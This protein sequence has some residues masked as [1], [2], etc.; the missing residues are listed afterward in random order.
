MVALPDLRPADL[1]RADLR[2]ADLSRRGLLGAVGAVA[3]SAACGAPERTDGRVR[4]GTEHPDQYGV[5]GLPSGA[6]RG[7]AILVHGGFWLAQYKADLMNAMAADLRGRGYATWNVEYRRVGDGGGYPA[8][9]TDIAAA[10]DKVGDLGLPDGLPAFSVGHSAGGQLAVWAASRTA[11]T[12]G[13]VPRFTP[14]TTISLSGVL[15]LTSAAQE[16]LGNGA[17]EGLMGASPTVAPAEYRLADPSELVPAQGTVIAVHAEDDQVV[18]TVQSS[19]YV[20]LAKAAGGRAEYFSVPGGHFELI[21][22]ATAAWK[23]IGELL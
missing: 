4:Y 10:F 17:A 20:Q 7:L 13:G 19:T 22:P 1:R 5:L 18:P 11:R 14:D 12:P 9:F 6:P 16:Y 15:D 23:Q 2:R 3:F 21:D 8:T